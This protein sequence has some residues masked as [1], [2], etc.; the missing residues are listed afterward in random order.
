MASSTGSRGLAASSLSTS[1]QH[2]SRHHS[3]A[4]EHQV[5]SANSSFS[6]SSDD[7]SEDD[8]IVYSISDLSIISA[9]HTTA[10]ELSSD[11]DFV[12][13][14][15]TDSPIG[16]QSVPSGFT[17]LSA[18]V[19]ESQAA[20]SSFSEAFSHLQVEDS[21]SDSAVRP[22]S[23]ATTR[24]RRRKGRANSP[25]TDASAQPPSTSVIQPRTAAP[26]EIEPTPQSTVSHPSTP[27][28][29]RRRPRNTPSPSPQPAGTADRAEQTVTDDGPASRKQSA[30]L[31]GSFYQE[32]VQ[33]IST[34]VHT[35]EMSY[36]PR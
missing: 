14:G 33:Y 1:F 10:D 29:K 30:V 9:P 3:P 12:L 20:S 32:A 7:S 2:L 26:R 11:D 34:C 13:L 16:V 28:R 5:H 24:R 21:D 8:E 4:E 23:Q 18:S 6:T 22:M 25:R 17:S 19:I 35:A 27:R 36:H 31:S 15:R